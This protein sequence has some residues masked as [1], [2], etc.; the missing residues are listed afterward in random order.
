VV[1]EQQCSD[2]GTVGG[3]DD[4]DGGG[5]FSLMVFRVTT[6]PAATP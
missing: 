5:E 3:G 4:G 1:Q 6:I 2:N